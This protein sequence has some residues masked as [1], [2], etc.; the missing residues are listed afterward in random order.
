MEEKQLDLRIEKEAEL[1]SFIL[2][3]M[4]F[5]LLQKEKKIL[6]GIGM[7]KLCQLL[8]TV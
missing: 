1:K 2:K 3:M 5:G 4:V 7:E 8:R 6:S